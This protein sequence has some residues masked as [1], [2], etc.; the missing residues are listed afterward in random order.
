[1]LI[2]ERIIGR[3]KMEVW[4]CG[5]G[6]AGQAERTEQGPP[7]ETLRPRVRAGLDLAGDCLRVKNASGENW[8]DLSLVLVANDGTEFT[9]SV[10][11]LKAGALTQIPITNFLNQAGQ[12]AKPDAQFKRASIGGNGFRFGAYGL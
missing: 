3:E 2:G 9:N 5:V 1:M 7:P 10:S 6:Q 8:P 4:D 11:A 12:R